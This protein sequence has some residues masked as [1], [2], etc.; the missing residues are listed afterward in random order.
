MSEYR[1]NRN[2][3]LNSYSNMH[4]VTD[5]VLQI[6]NKIKRLNETSALVSETT[7]ITLLTPLTFRM[8]SKHL[9]L[10]KVVACVDVV[11]FL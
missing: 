7:F 4:S 2:V 11:S 10:E 3:P 6:L 8:I 9:S 1:F 5:I